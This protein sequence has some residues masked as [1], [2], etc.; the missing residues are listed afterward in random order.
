[1]SPNIT[2]YKFSIAALAISALIAT[3]GCSTKTAF[4]NSFNEKLL[5]PDSLSQPVINQAALT[6]NSTVSSTAKNPPSQDMSLRSIAFVA[7][8]QNPTISIARW[9]AVGAGAAV[10]LAKVKTRPKIAFSFSSG[11][12]ASYAANVDD[13]STQIRTETSFTLSQLIYDFGKVSNEISYAEAIKIA[14]Q[15]RLADKVATILH[16]VSAIYLEVLEQD[17]LIAN[18]YQNEKAHKKTYNLVKVSEE[19]GNATKA[20]VQKAFTRLEGARTQTHDLLS[21]RQRSASEFRRLTGLEPD[22]L[23]IPKINN[24]IAELKIS[25][26]EKYFS[27]NP[28]MQ[29]LLIEK[30]ALEHQ[31]TALE[32]SY[33]PVLSLEGAGGTKLN[34]GATSPLTADARIQLALRGNIF[35]GGSTKAKLAQA[36]AKLGENE[37][38]YRKE[39]YK[40][41]N[42]V[43]DA[44]RILGTARDKSKSI[45]SRI[46]ASEDVVRLYTEQFKA[47]ERGIFELLDA[48]QELFA[49]KAEQISNSYDILRAKYSAQKLTGNLIP[50]LLTDLE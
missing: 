30:Q 39:R 17:L 47:G 13:V 34:V 25:D 26:I 40:V 24:N 33:L 41:E 23:S 14:S 32:R 45:R 27:Q 49:A 1:M 46:R 6:N 22:N 11:P 8:K 20:D 9:Q 48:Q 21:R 43:Y 16:A 28:K 10:S 3:S 36:V 12:E 5:T 35:D 37:A 19:G 29:A 50:N 44:I 4:Q 15:K 2:F 31:K 38:R 42:E 7:L 18:S